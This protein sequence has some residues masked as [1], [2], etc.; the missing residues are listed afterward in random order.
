[1][2]KFNLTPLK[3]LCL[4]LFLFLS[5]CGFHLRGAYHFPPQLQNVYVLYSQPFDPLVRKITQSLQA[6]G[7]QLVQD[8]AQASY[9]LHITQVNQ[10]SDLYAEL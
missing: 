9:I 6:S 4:F 7:V 2:N 5:A 3:W 8:A 1:M 10:T